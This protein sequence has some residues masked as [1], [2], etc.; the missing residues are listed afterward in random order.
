MPAYG[1]SENA[2]GIPSGAIGTVVNVLPEGSLKPR[3]VQFRGPVNYSLAAQILFR[4]S[5]N[6]LWKDFHNVRMPN[7]ECEVVIPYPFLDE[8]EIEYP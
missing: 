1:P 2:I 7:Y 4:K 5:D 8:I 6:S 3:N